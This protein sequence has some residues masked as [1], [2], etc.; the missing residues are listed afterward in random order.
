M[1]SYCRSFA[2]PA[3]YNS[4]VSQGLTDHK[5][6]RV[7]YVVPFIIITAVA[8]GMLFTCEDTPTGKWSQRHLMGP[9]TA[10]TT[11]NPE[12]NDDAIFSSGATTPKTMHEKVQPGPDTEA[13]VD[14]SKG[15]V[16]DELVVT[17]T[18]KET[19][20][21]VFSLPTLS[22][23]VMYACTFGA[24]LSFDSFLGSYYS[25]NFHTMGQTKSGQWAAMFG[26]LNVV[27]RPLGG[28]IADIIYRHTKSVWAKKILLTFL[29]I[30]T[31]GFLLAI[32]LTNPTSQSTM[33]GLVAGLAF[34][35]EA[36]NGANF[37]LVPHVYPF[38]NGMLHRELVCVYSSKRLLTPF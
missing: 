1:F 19:L 20:Q 29:T 32:G 33:F 13:Q 38:A 21:V 35:L 14:S 5:A 31:G 24:E 37:A 2:M 30:V 28:Y 17:P 6:W 36:A 25:L 15:G 22:L 7:A 34:F 3:I 8:L 27:C 4:L 10:T 18:W 23:A 12:L 26:L 16:L 9:D 11:P